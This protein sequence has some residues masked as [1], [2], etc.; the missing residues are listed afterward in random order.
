[1]DK[2]QECVIS[3]VTLEAILMITKEVSSIALI[4]PPKARVKDFAREY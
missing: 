1:M 3:H 4:C 2:N